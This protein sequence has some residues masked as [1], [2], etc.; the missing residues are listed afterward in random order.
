MTEALR[1]AATQALIAW[2]DDELLLGHR[3]SEWTGLGPIIEA[4]IALS[5]IAQDEMGH[6]LAW[7]ELAHSLGA[8]DPDTLV[9]ERGPAAYRNATLSELPRGDWA[10][11]ILRH[12]L[13]DL[14]EWVRLEHWQQ[15]PWEPWADIA[16]RITREEKYHL[17]HDRTW[18]ERLARGTEESHN[19]LQQALEALWPHALG[20]WEPPEG[21]AVLVEAGW[22]P[23]SSALQARWEEEVRAYLGALDLR[24]PQAS[25]H[26]G[27][28]RG[29]HTEHL[30]ALLEAMQ[31]LHR[32]I[33]GAK[34]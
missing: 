34:W 15:I 30:A 9:F 32:Q 28:R 14:A 16:E 3:D 11:C 10:F 29:H 18:L 20:L 23:S 21:E 7:Y 24:L 12:Y 26:L 6:A 4:D 17:L 19:R 5:S 8:P 1:V 31:M 2:A 25:A 22:I 27:G 13:F 33:P